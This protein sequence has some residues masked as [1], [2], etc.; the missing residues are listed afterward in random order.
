MLRNHASQFRFLLGMADVGLCAAVFALLL[1][2]EVDWRTI[3]TDADTQRAALVG[4]VACV[5]WPVLLARRQLYTSYRREQMRALAGR[6]ASAGGFATLGIAAA[7]FAVS[8][9]VPPLFAL[10]CGGLQLL[11]VSSVRVVAILGLRSLR[12]GGRNYRNII[13]VG[14]GQRACGVEESIHE[15]PEWGL[16][17]FGFIDTGS[18]PIDGRIAP[19]R[20]HPLDGLP[21]LLRDEVIDEVIVAWPRSL[22][23]DLDHVVACCASAGVPVT[24]ISD[25]FGDD[26]PPPRISRLGDMPALNFAPVHHSPF[27]LALKRGIDVA[28]AIGCLVLAAPVIGL[29]ALAIKLD[30]PGPVFF[31]QQRCGLNGRRFEILKLRT[32]VMEAESQQESLAHLNEM[33]GPVFKIT[34]DPRVTAVGRFLRRW[35][36]DELP[37]LW[38][39][40]RGEMSLV[41]P[42]PPIPSEVRRYDVA[43]RRRLSMRPGLTCV[44]QVSGRNEIASFQDWVKM[45]LEYIDHWSLAQDAKLLA[46]TVPALLFRRGA[47]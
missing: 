34:D 39:V 4:L 36:L 2:S 9:P 5:T 30:S 26:L 33:D 46:R 3:A 20:I 27:Q 17:V 43:D 1:S 19:S 15:H 37:Q 16:R 35:S 6:L 42:R 38:N 28:G 7:S 47:S 18:A 14:T 12:R 40:V 21:E 8:L 24:L 32:M 45:D 10:L 44:W 13:V 23:A 11:A 22:F 29:A 25:F 31:R 41:G